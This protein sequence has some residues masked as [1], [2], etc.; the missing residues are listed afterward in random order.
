MNR[1]CFVLL[2][3]ALLCFCL[4]A[5]A[6]AAGTSAG[7]GG[8]AAKV[9]SNL[10]NIAKLI[11]AMAY[12]GG[13]AFAIGAIVKFKAHKDNPTQIPIGTPIALLFIGAALIFIPS[14]FST[15]GGTLFGSSGAVAG[16]SGITSFS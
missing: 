5:E 14:V 12:V 1:K 10:A 11:T 2:I 13:M 3:G 4:G 16:V 7:I 6:F 9:Q 15:A 8:V